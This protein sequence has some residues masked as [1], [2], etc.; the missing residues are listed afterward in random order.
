MPQ[1]E[2]MFDTPEWNRKAFAL[3]PDLQDYLDEDD[4]I[5]TLFFEL[6]SRCHEAYRAGDTQQL[7]RIYDYAEWCHNQEEKDIWNAA[8]VA[9]YKHLVDEPETREAIPRWLTPE[10]YE[11]LRGLFH[12]RLGTDEFA[13]LE[14]AYQAQHPAWNASVSAHHAAQEQQE[15]E[16]QPVLRAGVGNSNPAAAEH[17]LGYDI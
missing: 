4:T 12:Y 3:W 15:G 1:S 8:G 11:Q 5:Y 16:T 14:Q 17:A 13:I 10:L 6:S 9:F 7:T 2:A